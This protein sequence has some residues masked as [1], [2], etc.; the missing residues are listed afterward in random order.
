MARKTSLWS[1]LQRELERRQRA[2]QA[3]ERAEQQMIR[4]LTRDQ[5]QAE[6]RAA[7][8]DAAERKRQEQLAHDAG[9]AAARQMKAQLDA[10]VTK[11]WMLLISALPAPPRLPFAALKRVV[12][13]A[14]FSPG[15]LGEPAPGSA[16]GGFRAAAAL[17]CWARC[18]AAR[19]GMSGPSPKRRG[20]TR[21]AL[22][23]HQQDEDKR[24]S[25]LGKA[26]AA[27]DQMIRT[28][29]AE[30]RDHNAAVDELERSFLAG[31]PDAV[32][33]YFTQVLALS[34]YPPGFPHQYRV[35]YRPEPRE[36]VIEYRLPPGEVIPAERDFRYVKTR[37]EI[38]TLPRPEKQI[39]ELYASVVDQIALRT[40]WE[41]LAVPEGHD[42]VDAVVFNGIVPATNRATGQAEELHLISAPASRDT[43]AGLVLDQLDPASCLRH[44]KAIVSPHPYDL[45]PVEPVIEFEQA[46]YRFAEPVDALAGIDSRPDLLKMDWYKFENLIR[47]LFE[48]MGLEVH[49][50]Q[51]S[52]DE[53]I[54]AVAYNKTDIVHQ[55]E[56]LIQAKRYSRC[57]PANDVRALAGSVEEKRATAGV[58]VTTAW[59]GAETKA[60]AARN[61]RLRI[62]EGGEL[63]HLLAEHLDLDVR[64]DLG[65][66]PGANRSPTPK[67][68]RTHE[69]ALSRSRSRPEQRPQVV[70][71]V[72]QVPHVRRGAAFPVRVQVGQCGVLAVAVE[73][74]PG[75]PLDEDEH[76]PGGDVA[77]HAFP[78]PAQGHHVSS[79]PGNLAGRSA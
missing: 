26:R 31:V 48:A 20:P 69:R 67:H 7:Q 32:E 51:S 40:M 27:H 54:D 50:T 24:V 42:I 68:T 22:A 79:V 74:R 64:I 55:A 77:G 17:E 71:P 65:R 10:R 35:A 47:Q 12:Q 8:A 57:V 56:I 13:A 11:L 16:L 25:Q 43:F 2:T 23:G 70:E 53:G 37:R 3:R 14:P 6:R 21:Q 60:F 72:E 1:E 36:L 38:D 39:K 28:L 4:Q 34:Q 62:I 30:V 9:A 45:E 19:A 29:Q 61:N 15:D 52:R 59:V 63:K 49:V 41:C 33:E 76:L 46:K 58:L 73:G 66:P 18:W 78:E 44:L 5:E 75:L